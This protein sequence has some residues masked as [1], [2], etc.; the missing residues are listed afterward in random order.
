MGRGNDIHDW[1]EP[2]FDLPTKP[3]KQTGVTKRTFRKYSGRAET[4]HVCIITVARGLPMREERLP[5]TVRIVDPNGDE[6]LLCG[7]HAQRVRDRLLAL[8]FNPTERNT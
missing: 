8:P 3:R 2:L 4:C 6:Y 1:D 7:K 5:A